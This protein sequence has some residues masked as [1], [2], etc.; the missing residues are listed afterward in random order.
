MLALKGFFF[1]IKARWSITAP[2]VRSLL[3]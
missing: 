2:A 3:A 1:A